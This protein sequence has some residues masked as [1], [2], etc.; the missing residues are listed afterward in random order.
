MPEL[1][2]ELDPHLERLTGSPAPR[3][4]GFAL[5]LDLLRERSTTLSEM[6]E[7]ARFAVVDRIETDQKAAKK[8]LKPT[9]LPILESLSKGL[10]GLSANADDAD[11][12]WNEASI[13]KVFESVRAEHGDVGMGKLAQ[14]VRVALTGTSVSPGIY[15]T[16][17]A[18]GQ[19]LTLSRL[20]ATIARLQGSTS[21]A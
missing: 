14:P 1:L 16:L 21:H 4:P 18:V 3:T 6:A 13:E 2:T 11:G 17:V 5:L 19:P 9:A 20:D 15:Q 8:F 10:A 12:A 7:Q